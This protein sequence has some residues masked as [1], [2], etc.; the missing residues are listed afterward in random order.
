[1][2][3]ADRWERRGSGR[4]GLLPKPQCLIE[5]I[6]KGAPSFL[7][8]PTQI[9]GKWP[10]S[11]SSNTSPGT[12]GNGRFATDF[13]KWRSVLRL[14]SSYSRVIVALIPKVVVG[15]GKSSGCHWFKRESGWLRLNRRGRGQGRN[16]AL[17]SLP[18]MSPFRVP[19]TCIQGRSGVCYRSAGK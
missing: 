11:A 18:F 13:R 10:P 3:C 2:S 14:V 17:G 12:T 1:V 8:P 4:P 7:R 5:S 16:L 19:P 6:D 9:W 15:D